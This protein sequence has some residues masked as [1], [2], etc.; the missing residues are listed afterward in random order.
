MLVVS[1]QT[2]TPTKNNRRTIQS[3]R[4]SLLQR[5]ASRSLFLFI[6]VCQ[7]ASSRA[8]FSAGEWLSATESLAS[9]ALF[10]RSGDV[11][12]FWEVFY[13]GRYRQR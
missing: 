10:T 12:L 9:W 3:I 4:I 13:V 7:T 2:T 5:A 8:A 11:P 1:R 6:P